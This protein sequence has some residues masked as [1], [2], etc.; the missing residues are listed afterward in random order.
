VQSSARETQSFV[1]GKSPD[2][3]GEIVSDALGP[4]AAALQGVVAVLQV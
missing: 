2:E 3:V 1:S 4:N